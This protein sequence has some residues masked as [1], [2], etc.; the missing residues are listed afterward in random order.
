VVGHDQTEDRVAEE[1]QTLVG[2]RARVLGAPRAMGQ[3]AVQQLAVVESPLQP[4]LE[5]R[6]SLRGGD[7]VVPR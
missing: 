5:G 3:R 2:L 4:P 6:Q 1:L 7:L